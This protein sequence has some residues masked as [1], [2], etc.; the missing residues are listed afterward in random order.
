VTQSPLPAWQQIT[1]DQVSK[2]FGSRSSAYVALEA[3]S[4]EIPRRDFFC[5]L[6]PSGCGK[7]TLLTLL[8]GFEEP[9]S[10][11]IR[12]GDRVIEGPGVDRVVVFQDAG[13]ALFPWLTVVENVEYG[14]RM[15]HVKSDAY[16]RAA[17]DLLQ[18]V[19]LN[20]HSGKFP[21]EL[22]GGMKQRLQ[23]ARALVNEPEVLLMDEPF[24]S[25]DA[26]TKRTLQSE[27]ARIWR[28]TH[29]TIVYVTHDIIEAL[30]LGTHIAVMTT[31]P[32]AKVKAV[33]NVDL[34]P[35]DR[36]PSSD[37]FAALYGQVEALLREE[38]ER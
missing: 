31:G 5:L 21:H 20:A 29:V 2:T 22:S 14:P 18:M 9:T 23:I 38:V 26:I 32:R 13:A 34:E 37:H 35:K 15:R 33:L 1:V 10:G 27:L 3:V 7:S 19:G 28:S 24:A 30:L 4:L 11:S 17:Q 8:A 12:L 16:E 6:G 25:L 36:T